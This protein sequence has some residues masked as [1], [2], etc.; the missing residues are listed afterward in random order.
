MC[1]S[2]SGSSQY[3][4]YWYGMVSSSYGCSGWVYSSFRSFGGDGVRSFASSVGGV[5]MQSPLPSWVVLVCTQSYLAIADL[6]I[7]RVPLPLVPALMSRPTRRPSGRSEC[8]GCF[9]NVTQRSLHYPSPILRLQMP[10]HRRC[11]RQVS[12][13]SILLP[14]N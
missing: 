7:P 2:A 3:F 5:G 13:V 11:L 1:A 4:G 12:V 8:R 14:T 10:P 9:R 6:W